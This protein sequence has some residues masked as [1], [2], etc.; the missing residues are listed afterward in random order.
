[1]MKIAVLG[2]GNIGGTI[3]K[4]WAE[5]GHDVTFGVRNPADP[6]YQQELTGHASVASMAEAV[7]AGEVVLIAIPAP[8]VEATLAEIGSA[9]AGKAVIDATNQMGKPVFNNFESIAK[10]VPEVQ[11]FRAFSSLGW[12]NFAHPEINGVPIDL[13]YCGDAGP[14]QTTVNGL[15]ADMGM[16]PIYVG[17]R[18]QA[19]LID[20]TTRLWSTLAYAQ[21]YGRRMGFKVIR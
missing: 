11:L 20:S 6:K 13:F 14:A 7:A 17:G 3:G 15:I 2:M 1:M 5:K 4:K 9:M 8:V 18:D 16:N 12:E 19:G 10:N 21:G